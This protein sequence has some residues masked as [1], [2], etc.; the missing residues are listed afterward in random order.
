MPLLSRSYQWR[1]SLRGVLLIS[2]AVSGLVGLGCWQL[3]R[4]EQKR[5]LQQQMQQEPQR[6][7]TVAD[8][9]FQLADNPHWRYQSLELSG[10]Y[11]ANHQFLI[12]NQLQ[13]GKPGYNVLTPFIY[14][15]DKPA[16]LVNRGWIALGA[17]RATLP[18]IN[19]TQTQQTV[20]G[21]INQFPSVGFR[22]KGAEVPTD[23]W[24]ALVQVV[25]GK[26]LAA[27]LGYAISDFQLELAPELP[28]GYCRSWVRVAPIPPEK[29]LAYAVQWFG[30]ALTLAS[31]FVW[32]NLRKHSEHTA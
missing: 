19:I 22:L 3:D 29:H 23:G 13:D 10:Y 11:D 14:A 6:L 31:L 12:D 20:R 7:L 5:A 27:R 30:L 15:A 9:P 26:Q 2:V 4:A 24:P 16:L 8:L 32:H 18:D 1:G 28:E 25:E 21:A 17:N